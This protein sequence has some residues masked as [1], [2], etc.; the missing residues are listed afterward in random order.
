[1]NYPIAIHSDMLFW[2]NK[3]SIRLCARQLL[4][5]LFA[6]PQIS[7]LLADSTEEQKKLLTYFIRYWTENRH[8]LL[9]GDFRPLHPEMDYS[10]ISA[11]GDEKE[12][13][14][15]YADLPY[16]YHGKAC[17]LFHNGD[18]DGLIVEN[19]TDRPVQAQIFDNMGN[20]LSV[21]CIPAG[22]IL[23]LPVPP[24]GMIRMQ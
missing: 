23:R 24:T 17:D 1:M 3:E 9:H 8:I 5:I 15:V 4:N 18:Q 14:V 6:V 11:E 2:S 7:A 21:A 20:L 12:I 22:S 16:T 19:P 10:M 13:T